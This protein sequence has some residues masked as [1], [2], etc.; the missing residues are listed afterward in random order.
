M[1]TTGPMPWSGLTRPDTRL[2]AMSV[3]GCYGRQAASVG[4]QNQTPKVENLDPHGRLGQTQQMS[5]T[6]FIE[7]DDDAGGLVEM[8]TISPSIRP[9]PP[10]TPPQGGNRGPVSWWAVSRVTRRQQGRQEC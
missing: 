6:V 7:E 2:G 4:K 1:H 9:R 5:G 10:P 8:G 3:E